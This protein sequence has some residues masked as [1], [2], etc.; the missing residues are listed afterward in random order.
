[1]PNGFTVR[2]IM[3]AFLVYTK[4]NNLPVTTVDGIIAYTQYTLINQSIIYFYLLNFKAPIPSGILQSRKHRHTHI[5]EV[6]HL[7]Y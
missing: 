5:I 7:Q 3:V 4:K 1:M 2:L 6:V